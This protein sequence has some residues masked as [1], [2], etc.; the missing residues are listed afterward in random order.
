MT[1]TPVVS[2]ECHDR[3][4]RRVK[5]TERVAPKLRER[6]PPVIA[7]P[8]IDPPPEPLKSFVSNETGFSAR[9]EGP[10][11][12]LLL[13]P[14]LPDAFDD[15]MEVHMVVVDLCLHHIHV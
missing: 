5:Y 1:Y 2:D 7:Y 11:L 9:F 6:L 3:K 13:L 12:H 8:P 10:S 15:V 4:L 14:H